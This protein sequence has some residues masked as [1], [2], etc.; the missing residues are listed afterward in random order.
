MPRGKQWDQV[1]PA[2]DESFLICHAVY[3][4]IQMM[5]SATKKQS[6][7]DVESQ[8]EKVFRMDIHLN[9]YQFALGLAYIVYADKDTSMPDY[10]NE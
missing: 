7:M 8:I 3:N 5:S 9:P 1:A 4:L 6:A 2:N 10:Q